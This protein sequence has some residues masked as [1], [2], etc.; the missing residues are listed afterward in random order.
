MMMMS[1]PIPPPQH[2]QVAKSTSPLEQEAPDSYVS[3]KTKQRKIK[4]NFHLNEKKLMN[5][6]KKKN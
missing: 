1:A 2:Q 4:K 5:E 6:R 3:A